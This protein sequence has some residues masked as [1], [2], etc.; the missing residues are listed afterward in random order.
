MMNILLWKYLKLQTAERSGV[1][2]LMGREL[3]GEVYC[4]LGECFSL[5]CP[6]NQEIRAQC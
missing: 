4:G 5:L 6:A 3:L 1:G 2:A